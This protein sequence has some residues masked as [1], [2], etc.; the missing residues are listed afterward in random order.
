MTATAAYAAVAVVQRGLPLLL[1]PIYTRVLTPAEYADLG[2]LIAIWIG[3]TL[4]FSFG[5]EVSLFRN[6]FQTDRGT[7]NRRRLLE[8]GANLLLIV[9]L[10]VAAILVVPSVLTVHKWLMVDPLDLALVL[11][12]A[13]LFVSSTV[14]PFT[15]LRAEER[16]RDFIQLN[17]I[18]AVTTTALTLAFVVWLDWEVRGWFL[19]TIF[20]NL[21]T[22]IWT[23]RI[24]PWPWGIKLHGNDVRALL[25][26]GLP[27]IP[28]HLSF[29]GLQLANRVILVGLVTQVQVALFTLA[30]TLALPVTLLAGSMIYGVIPR[31]GDAIKD[32]SRRPALAGI[33][34]VQVSALASVGVAVAL[35]APAFCTL[36]FPPLY[37]RAAP[38]IPVI[39]L[40]LA[41]GALYAVPLN[42]AA[43]LAGRTTF[44]WVV[45]L[46]AASAN[47][48][49]LYAAVPTYGLEAAAVAVCVGNAVLFLGTAVYS[50]LV[51]RGALPY[52]WRRMS[53]S[54]AV[55]VGCYI[56]AVMTSGYDSPLDVVVR[57]LWLAGAASV[58]VR[59][60]IVPIGLAHRPV[61]Q[62]PG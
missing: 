42:A 52:E 55:L 53:W 19:A 5:Q 8:T 37:A 45:T 13:A 34:T 62:A 59:L 9:P 61:P 18:L 15:V 35:L 54:M 58:L 7:E 25:R 24:L 39:A 44:A 2:V 17:V 21:A 20:S 56:G 43:L 26:I 32:P 47:L 50:R 41:I 57:I 1:L 27:L 3:L 6:L 40:G 60:R 49:V 36:L 51:A 30:S 10:G 11:L 14:L 29:W 22:W 38:L 23:A 16:L 48:G 31:Y 46:L 28:H 33:V 12:S 4:I